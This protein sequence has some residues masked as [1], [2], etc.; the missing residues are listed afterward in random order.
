LL[1]DRHR[2]LWGK[3]HWKEATERIYKESWWSS[4]NVRSILSFFLPLYLSSWALAHW[5]SSKSCH[6]SHNA[7]DSGF[8]VFTL[9][10]RVVWLEA[11][12]QAKQ[13]GSEIKNLC[14]VLHDQINGSC[15]SRVK[16]VREVSVSKR[17]EWWNLEAAHDNQKTRN[18]WFIVLVIIFLE[19]F[20][21]VMLKGTFSDHFYKNL[22]ANFRQILTWIFLF[23]PIQ[24]I[25][26]EKKRPKFTRFLNFF[27]PKLTYFS[28]KFP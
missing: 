11:T 7:L 22:G 19:L 2:G 12:T 16:I 24:R 3:L 18:Q 13:N 17:S 5:N 4:L 15:W 26:H 1:L 20:W 10:Y 8:V 14:G 6:W 27:P 23:E 28:D 25:F 21:N 9:E